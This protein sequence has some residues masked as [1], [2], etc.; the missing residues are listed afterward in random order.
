MK[1]FIVFIHVVLGLMLV[2]YSVNDQLYL[3]QATQNPSSYY[4]SYSTNSSVQDF[5]QEI[6]SSLPQRIAITI[7]GIILGLFSIIG[8]MAFRKNK[9]WAIL[10]LPLLPLALSLW[11]VYQ[12]YS[13]PPEAVAWTGGIIMLVALIL[14]ALFILEILYIKLRK[15]TP[16]L[17]T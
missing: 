7:L 4:P 12:V 11:F 9:R 1:I 3:Y 14:F 16:I 6:R 13:A 15:Q 8:S 17:H 5:V 10:T 2:F